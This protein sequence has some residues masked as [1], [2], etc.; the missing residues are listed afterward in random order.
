MPSPR[1]GNPD[2]ASLRSKFAKIAK[3]KPAALPAFGCELGFL[4]SSAQRGPWRYPRFATRL[5][6]N[7]RCVPV[8]NGTR[9]PPPRFSNIQNPLVLSI[10]SHRKSVLP[11]RDM[12]RAR[13][14]VSFVGRRLSSAASISLLS[15]PCGS[16]RW[17]AGPS[18]ERCRIFNRR[19]L[20]TNHRL[21]RPFGN[22]SMLQRVF[23][24]SFFPLSVFRHGLVLDVA[25]PVFGALERGPV[26]KNPPV[27]PPPMNN[28]RRVRCQKHARPPA[29]APLR[30][31]TVRES[32]P[33]FGRDLCWCREYSCLLAQRCGRGC[34]L[35]QTNPAQSLPGFTQLVEEGS[36]RCIFVR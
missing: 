24:F 29:P 10:S 14:T 8:V 18:A 34:G 12:A 27:H 13:Q 4:P 21:D 2:S 22:R 32:V 17:A 15:G 25:A 16:G 3:T 33:H 9:R 35:Q 20:E 7:G 30:S 5:R 26:R 28:T 19:G 31:P 6:S 23:F 1:K 36:N 11:N